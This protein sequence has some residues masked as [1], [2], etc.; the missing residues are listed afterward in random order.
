MLNSF[1]YPGESCRE[2]SG[3]SYNLY[4]VP[5]VR[6]E[7]GTEAM[8]KEGATLMQSSLSIPFQVSV[9]YFATAGRAI[10]TPATSGPMNPAQEWG[11]DQF[12]AYPNAPVTTGDS[13]HPGLA[14]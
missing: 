1:L 10:S 8:N 11:K 3:L 9:R 6:A 7:L 2:P 14:V 12:G 13:A 4:P 5:R